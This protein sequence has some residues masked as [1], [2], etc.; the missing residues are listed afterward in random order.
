MVFPHVLS[1]SPDC[2]AMWRL[3]TLEEL[4]QQVSRVWCSLSS[5]IRSL[6]NAGPASCATPVVAA[7][8]S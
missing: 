2:R 5:L 8:G 7:A 1:G 3:S 4:L 6:A